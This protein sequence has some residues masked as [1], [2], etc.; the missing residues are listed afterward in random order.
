MKKLYLILTAIFVL[1][2]LFGCSDNSNVTAPDGGDQIMLVQRPEFVD[3]R[4][5]DVKDSYTI[6]ASAAHLESSQKKPPQPP[7]DPEPGDDPNPN[8]PHKYAL[9]IGISDYEGTAN[10][11]Q[12]ADDDANEIAQYF[13]GEG[14]SVTKITNRSATADNIASALAALSTAADAG[15]EIAFFYSGHGDKLSVGSCIIST[16][17]YY[18]SHGYIM[19][20]INA[21]ACSK[22]LVMLDACK[23]G[24]FLSDGLTGSVVATASNNTYS[25]DAPTL[26]N[27]AWTYYWLEA[28]NGSY[29][30]AEDCA[31]Q[32]EIGM[33]AWASIYHV[34]VSPSH[35]D[36]Y[37]GMF[38][39]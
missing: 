10:D 6:T 14:F 17:L 37:S 31:E 39:M 5:Q 34:R 1:I 3:T 23:I 32:A 19:S 13:Q 12:F 16:D 22:V 35:T 24:S 2:M 18:I 20:Y 9:V 36:K 25:Y 7:P 28:A 8:P 21:T 38:D 26:N 4:P 33:K 29:V 27:G 11:L 30:Y 15:D